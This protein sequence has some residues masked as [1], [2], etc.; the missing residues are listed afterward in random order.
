M[1]PSTTDDPVT[2]YIGLGANLGDTAAALAAALAAL[3]A[4]PDTALLSV[5]PWY[6][7][8]PVDALGPD[9]TNAVAALSTRLAAD[10]LLAQLHRIEAAQGRERPYRN[11]PRRLDLDLLLY[12]S[13]R[14]ETPHLSVPHPRLHERAFV[15]RPLVDVAPALV[16][17][18][19][20][21]AV[22]LLEAVRGQRIER[23]DG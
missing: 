17:P 21:P 9:Y 10:A 8:A 13:E 1:R 6:R 15:L 7:S 18:G 22:H 20:G 12:G 5:S 2:A 16:V 19:R 23:V 11:A 14:I 3:A 4:L